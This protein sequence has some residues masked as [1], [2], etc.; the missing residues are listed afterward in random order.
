LAGIG[1]SAIDII[2]DWVAGEEFDAKDV[3]SQLIIGAFVGSVFDSGLGFLDGKLNTV[4]SKIIKEAGPIVRRFLDR[5]D[6]YVPG[7]NTRNTRRYHELWDELRPYLAAHAGVKVLQNLEI[8]GI[9][10]VAEEISEAL[11]ETFAEST[12]SEL[13]S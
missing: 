11:V 12:F 7:T 6:R 8:T 10:T 3:A 13:F 9:V 1:G 2:G 5:A 4:K